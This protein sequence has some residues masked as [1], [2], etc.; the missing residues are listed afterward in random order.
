MSNV[1]KNVVTLPASG[2]SRNPFVTSLVRGGFVFGE[3]VECYFAQYAGRDT[4]L[5]G[6]ADFFVSQFGSKMAHE[7]DSDDVADAIEVLANRGKLHCQGN[8]VKA[9]GKNLS[10]ATL[11][12]YRACVQAILTFARKRRLMPKGW[13]NPVLETE[14]YGEDNARTRFLDDEEYDRLLKCCKISQ[15]KKLHLLVKM[16]VVTG[17]RRGALLSLTWSDVDLEEGRVYVQRTKNGSAHVAVLTPDLV[18]ELKIHK[19]G[20]KADWLIFGGRNPLKPHRFDKAW[21]YALKHARIDDCCFHS[22][23]HSHA[24]ALAKAGV[25][26]LTI[27]ASLGHKSLAMTQRYSHLSTATRADVINSIFGSAA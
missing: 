18:E 12:R 5:K 20:E 1:S 10:P 24:S 15:W 16:A 9:T 19:T 22:L 3:L 6:R 26:L 27:A 25:P 8:E 23:R 7:I 2:V 21:K 17:L 14:R 4:S 13:T 11:N